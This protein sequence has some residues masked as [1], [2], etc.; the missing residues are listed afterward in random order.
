MTESITD[1]HLRETA[2]AHRLRR[3]FAAERAHGSDRQP[4]ATTWR[5]M[6]RRGAAIEELQKL[7]DLRRALSPSRSLEL[8][9]A[10]RALAQEVGRASEEAKR[11]LQQ[12]G[13]DLRVR[14]GAGASTGIRG[15]SNGRLL[16]RS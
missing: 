11:R 16:G 1:L 5:I 4:A 2:V 8:D 14:H 12:I 13:E 10:L 7:D 9:R 3:L 15:S 6:E